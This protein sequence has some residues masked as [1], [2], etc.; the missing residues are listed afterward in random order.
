MRNIS[1][2]SLNPSFLWFKPAMRDKKDILSKAYTYTHYHS[3][4]HV[5]MVTFSMQGQSEKFT[6]ITGHLWDGWWVKGW[7][8]S[9]CRRPLT[10]SSSSKAL[11]R[12][13]C[14]QMPLIL[15][16]HSDEVKVVFY[17][18]K[19]KLNILYEA[20]LSESNRHTVPR[21]DISLLTTLSSWISYC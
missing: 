9:N 1:H 11:L 5:C 8:E 10:Q 2:V 18:S 12:S 13:L 14:S 6:E 4:S 3:V 21:I 17:S 7:H 19:V 20:E 16:I 15:R